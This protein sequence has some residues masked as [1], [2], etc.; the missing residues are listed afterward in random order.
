[1]KNIIL[2][3]VTIALTAGVS[4]VEAGVMVGEEVTLNT[5]HLYAVASME[6]P[7]N[8]TYHQ[9]TGEVS[10]MAGIAV[11]SQNVLSSLAISAC[12]ICLEPLALT[13]MLRNRNSMLP[14]DPSLLELLK[15]A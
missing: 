8:S 9:W 15:P 13:E 3:I 11:Q 6:Q 10:E 4:P 12:G 7:T 2:L 5:E 1:M 14:S